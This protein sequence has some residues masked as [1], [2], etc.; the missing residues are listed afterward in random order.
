MLKIYDVTIESLGDDFRITWKDAKQ[1]PLD[2][3]TNELSSQGKEKLKLW[4]KTEHQLEIGESLFQFL[5]GE[6]RHFSPVLDRALEDGQALQINL[7]TCKETADWPFELLAKD[8][9]FLLLK[10]LH[11][12]RRVS[13][14]GIDSKVTPH[15]RSLRLLFM[16]CD[17]L[18]LESGLNYDQEEET[19]V[20]ITQGLALELEV[21][22]SGSLT[23]LR[24][25][26]VP[27]HYDVVHLSGHAN[28][29]N[30]KPIF[31]MESNTGFVST[32]SADELW[33][34]ALI[35]NSPQL[36]FLSGCRSG[37][38]A[39]T[40]SSDYVVSFARLMVEGY[41]I[42]AVL[43]WGRSVRDVQANHGEKTIYYELSRG[44]SI[45][46]AVRKARCE[47]EMQSRFTGHTESAWPLLRLYSNGT[48]L[49]AIVSSGQHP[50]PQ[51]RHTTY[52]YLA[53]SRVK[54]LT[55]GF[56][57]RRRQIQLGLKTLNEDYDKQG[58]L[59][60]GTGGLGKSCL[61]GKLCERFPG[62]TVIAHQGKLD[63]VSFE[64]V[65]QKVFNGT[66]DNK[67]LEVLSRREAMAEKLADLCATSF[68]E[69]NYI[70]L[71]DAFEHNL[72]KTDSGWPG[73][74]HPGAAELLRPMLYYLPYSGKMTHLV[75]TSRYMF[76]LLPQDRYLMEE[77]LQEIWLTGFRESEVLRKIQELKNIFGHE[78][79]T[80]KK[81]LKG[82][83]CGNP[84][85]MEQIDQIA[86]QIPANEKDR[87]QEEIE[88]ARENFLREL[89]LYELYQQTGEPLKFILGTLSIYSNP[90]PGHQVEYEAGLA[91]IT[92]W[93]DLLREGMNLGLVE[94][95]QAKRTYSVTPLLKEKLK[96]TYT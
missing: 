71:L 33:N 3:F 74:L 26:L 85:L 18:D 15:N 82:A 31:Y 45:L 37:Q 47:M 22:D 75:I 2:S 77:R 83:G 62:H 23:G 51:S 55:E 72:E 69:R 67:G 80:M 9:E 4:E 14:R 63:E 76:S 27:K 89:R 61:A 60:L 87:L 96:A 57:G 95:D 21:E 64:T 24:H 65:L 66:G 43:G 35:E 81:L 50:K 52:T 11:L 38:M 88:N 56:I 8:G 10:H 41:K 44:S 48:P 40:G 53:H 7:H 46:E 79:M 59:L 94:H 1:K 5:A 20:E 25:R 54:V 28:I 73:P 6:A 90:V 92:Q 42:P 32:I 84:F 91:G 39:S 12:V 93:E 78:N 30:H 19:I 70:I 16:A 17:P 29:K 49:K 36:L 13:D 34:E 86:G 68:K 58:I